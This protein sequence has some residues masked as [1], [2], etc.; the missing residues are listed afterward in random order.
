MSQ[1]RPFG[2]RWDTLQ[3]PTILPATLPSR[4]RNSANISHW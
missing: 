3:Q 2:L 4:E 1:I